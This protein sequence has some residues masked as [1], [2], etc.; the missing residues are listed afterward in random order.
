MTTNAQLMRDAFSMAE[1]ALTQREVPVGCVVVDEDGST[2]IARGCNQVN[3]TRNAT[4]HAEM[5]IIDHLV[6]LSKKKGVDLRDMCSRC[7]LYV[8]VEPCVMC[9]YALRS[10][11]LTRVIFGCSNGRFGGCGS[12]LQAA[13]IELYPPQTDSRVERLPLPPLRIT[14]GVMEDEAIALL[15]QFYK[16]ENPLAPEDKVKHKI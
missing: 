1:Q 5:I 16:G 4:R 13:T 6:E 12:V 15:Q 3:A 7:T 9:T 11:G 8:T 2:I 10:V 14:S